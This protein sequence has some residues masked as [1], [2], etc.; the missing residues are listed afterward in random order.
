MI[1]QRHLLA[2]FVLLVLQTSDAADAATRYVTDEFLITLRSGQSTQHE[3][4]QQI[5]S[6]TPV[7][8]IRQGRDYTHV[9]LASGVE[10]W[11]LSRYLMDMPSGRD[12][13][14]ALQ[15]KYQQLES[16]FEQRVK[17]EKAALQKKIARLEALAQK[18]LT[19]EKEN[20]KL[21]TQLAAEKQ[22]Y[23][24]LRAESE[25]LKSPLKDRH[26]FTT[27]ALTV[28]GSIIFGIL[29]TR[30]PWR[31]KKKWNQL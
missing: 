2:G 16:G 24:A 9:R 6:G 4:R 18:P 8:V 28:I 17:R 25:I 27:G 15:K 22:R 19:L 1:V 10:G 26:W 5:K 31:K 23:E 11:V 29:L 20:N 21:T 30:I 13:L 14:G 7:E 3:I 12:R